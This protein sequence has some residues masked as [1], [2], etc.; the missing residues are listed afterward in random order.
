VIAVIEPD[1]QRAGEYAE[2][3]QVFVRTYR[4]LTG[5]DEAFG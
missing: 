4:A 1:P 2:R 5:I 3:C